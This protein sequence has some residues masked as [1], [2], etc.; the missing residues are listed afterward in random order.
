MTRSRGTGAY[1]EAI[2][3]LA[4]D[5]VEQRVDDAGAD[6][7]CSNVLVHVDVRQEVEEGI[8]KLESGFR[9]TIGR[10]LSLGTA[11]G[12]RK[13]HARGLQSSCSRSVAVLLI[14][15]MRTP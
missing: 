14:N 6:H 15:C 3:A 8:D 4:L 1:D 9:C 7:H 12:T 13:S 10:E 5:K 11:N 2:P